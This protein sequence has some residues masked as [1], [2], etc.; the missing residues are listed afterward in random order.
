MFSLTQHY[1][2]KK[3]GIYFFSLCFLNISYGQDCPPSV[4]E[5]QQT[6]NKFKV[7]HSLDNI[8]FEEVDNKSFFYPKTRDVS[9]ISRGS[10]WVAGK[11]PSGTLRVS[12]QLHRNNNRQYWFAG[13]YDPETNCEEW[14]KMFALN[15]LDLDLFKS[16]LEDGIIDNEI[17]YSILAWPGN[18]NPHFEGIHGFEMPNSDYGYAAFKDVDGD[19][20]YDPKKGDYPINNG[21]D[22]SSWGIINDFF[23]KAEYPPLGAE[24]Q[25]TANTF[26]NQGEVLDNSI[27]YEVK[28]INKSGGRLTDMGFTIWIYPELG[29]NED[30]YFGCSPDDNLV[31][32]YNIDAID[33]ATGAICPG[34]V[35]TY[36]E[37]IPLIGIK[38]LEPFD[39]IGE[40]TL[41]LSSVIFHNTVNDP[42]SFTLGPWNRPENY[43]NFM[44]GLWNDGSPMTLGGNGV[45][46]NIPTKFIFP[47][48]PNSDGWSLCTA[49]IPFNLRMLMLNFMPFELANDESNSMTFAV[50]GVENVPHPCPDITPLIE[51]TDLLEEV[52]KNRITTSSS[53]I[54]NIS[55]AA[56]ILSPNPTSGF[57]SVSLAGNENIENMEL[58]D[59]QGQVI[60]V[61]SNVAKKE[62]RI[63]LNHLAN[64]VY[65]LF[66]RTKSGEIYNRK[67][68]KMG[69]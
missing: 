53:T 57:V 12:P 9:A 35:K 48:P 68:I 55:D 14:D 45:G 18:G 69:R 27:I 61:F 56:L 20:I 37:E 28:L 5:T 33:G 10:F 13:P 39:G 11:D 47:D 29:C 8:W 4:S 46:G 1:K 32:I 51:R 38:V 23:S 66:L 60:K 41:N 50:T 2:M 25:L 24:I 40:E 3:L 59:F 36:G 64:G 34:G 43:Y 63:D 67:V 54:N 44:S 7:I 49:Q 21:A 31:Y 22:H 42:P 65:L 6:S 30:D 17:P 15:K 62:I 26:S 16:D 19:K 58:T 52:W